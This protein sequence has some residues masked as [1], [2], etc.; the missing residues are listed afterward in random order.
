MT[1]SPDLDAHLGFAHL[2]TFNSLMQTLLA[3]CLHRHSN[4]SVVRV[5]IKQNLSD[6]IKTA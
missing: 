3:V 2:M 6:F 5:E 1:F 4:I